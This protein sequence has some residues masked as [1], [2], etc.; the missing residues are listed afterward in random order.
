M[1]VET[2]RVQTLATTDANP[3]PDI[4][5]ERRAPQRPELPPMPPELRSIMEA[6]M[7][8]HMRELRRFVVEN[9][10]T[11]ADRIIGDVRLM[12]QEA[13]APEALPAPRRSTGL[14]ALALGVLAAVA[15]IVAALFA[16]QW[17]TQ[18]NV[19]AGLRT[20]LAR[21]AAAARRYAARAAGVAGGR[22]RGRGECRGADR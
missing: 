16:W 2:L 8:H 1:S 19:G 7:A 21:S 5:M 13:P 6:M 22:C 3:P 4:T 18:R 11:Q 17:S 14:G 15:L 10:E 12:L 9:L 20:Q